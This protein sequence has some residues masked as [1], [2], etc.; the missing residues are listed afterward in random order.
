MDQQHRSVID[1]RQV[2]ML[3]IQLF[4]STLKLSDQNW[5]SAG[6]K[7]FFDN[8]HSLDSMYPPTQKTNHIK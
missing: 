6:H 8:D 2:G 7:F 4:L 5:H 3:H 1:G